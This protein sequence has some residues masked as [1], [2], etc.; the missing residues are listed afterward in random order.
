VKSIYCNH[1]TRV[2]EAFKVQTDVGTLLIAK[3]ETRLQFT[4]WWSTLRPS[5]INYGEYRMKNTKKYVTLASAAVA[6]ALS[7]SAFA[8]DQPKG[9]S[10]AAIDAG[11]KVHCYGVHSCKGNSDCKTAEHACKGQNSCGGHGFKGM[12]AKA[13][14]DAGGTIADIKG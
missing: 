8:A 6:L 10:G 2:N 7:T 3:S 9:S 11:D 12:D 14:L 1:P 5:H 4:Y 13:C